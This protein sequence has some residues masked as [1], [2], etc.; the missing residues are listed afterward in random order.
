MLPVPL[1]SLLLPSLRRI[2]HL[3]GVGFEEFPLL[4]LR[5]LHTQNLQD[6]LSKENFTILPR[7]SV[8]PDYQHS[9][10]SPLPFQWHLHLVAYVHMHPSLYGAE[11]SLRDN[12]VH[13]SKHIQNRGNFL[14]SSYSLSNNFDE[15]ADERDLF[16]GS[17][18]CGISCYQ[19]AFYHSQQ[20][21]L[22]CSEFQ[23]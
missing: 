17:T 20:G 18:D 14:P 11:V 9:L 19:S 16:C 22:Y 2:E 15:R 1:H 13:C 23:F 7:R 5:I 12:L 4:L 3:W 21:G 6:D 8:F 10:C